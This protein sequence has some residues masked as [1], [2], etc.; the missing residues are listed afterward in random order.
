MNAESILQMY[1]MLSNPVIVVVFGIVIL[2]IVR[3]I[4]LWYWRINKI[5]FLQQ[6]Q[7]EILEAMYDEMKVK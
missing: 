4:I 5:V 6:K 7:M 2:F 1:Q 3:E